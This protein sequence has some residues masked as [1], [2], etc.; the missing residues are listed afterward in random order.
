MHQI[1]NHI[2]ILHPNIKYKHEIEHR[3]KCGTKQQQRKWSLIQPSNYP[4]THINI[5][6]GIVAHP[7]NKTEHLFN[8]WPL[9]KI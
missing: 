1:I 6:D 3:K 5:L 2:K 8:T 4:F 7:I 9:V